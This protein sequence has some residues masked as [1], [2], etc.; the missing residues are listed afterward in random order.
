MTSSCCTAQL[1]L[2]REIVSKC[3][4]ETKPVNQHLDFIRKRFDE[5][6]SEGFIWSKQSIL[7]I[8]LQLGLSESPI[9]SSA[10]VNQTTESHVRPTVKIPFDGVEEDTG[11][12]GLRNTSHAV[13]L[14]DLPIEVFNNILEKLDCLAESEKQQITFKKQS[15]LVMI[16]AIPSVREPYKTYLH[17]NSPILNLT[18]TFSLTSREIYRRCEPWLWRKLQFP[19]S[20]PAPIDLWT[21]DILLKRGSHVRSLTLTLSEN[22][23]KPLDE[24]ADYDPFYDNLIPMCKVTPQPIS[25]KNIR[26]LIIRCPNISTLNLCNKHEEDDEDVGRTD[27]FLSDLV[28][29]L[30]SLKQLQHLKLHDEYGKTIMTDFP[31]K[32]VGSL[33]LL[34]S[35]IIRARTSSGNQQTVGDASLGYNLSKLKYLSR[36]ELWANEDID[37]TWCLYDWPRTITHLRLIR[38]RSLSFSSALRVIRHISPYLT[39]LELDFTNDQDDDGFDIDPNWDPQSHPVFPSLTYLDLSTHEPRSLLSFQECK[40][41]LHLKWHFNTLDHIRSL[42]GI[43]R[44]ATWPYLKELSIRFG[45]AARS[46]D[47][48]NQE[49]ADQLVAIATFCKQ[50]NVKSKMCRLIDR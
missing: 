21:E 25:P 17:R 43:L 27:A 14:M 26:D 20:H 49:W 48:Q 19:S 16:T 7:G 42:D 1:A 11:D 9:D 36:L 18:Q 22:C 30:S 44:K 31:A 33:P 50:H 4:Q 8:F 37:E 23:K 40:T 39:T 29:L 28:P 34:K 32:V 10:S 2:W 13:G 5:L 41:L 46:S 15:A 45:P 38:C 6:D 12:K 47:V 24:F 35:L 3:H